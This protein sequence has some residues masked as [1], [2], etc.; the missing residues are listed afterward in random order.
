M[1]RRRDER[2]FASGAQALAMRQRDGNGR[3]PEVGDL[4]WPTGKPILRVVLVDV[5]RDHRRML[6]QVY[7]SAG[8]SPVF[9]TSRDMSA[10]WPSRRGDLVLVESDLSFGALHL[11]ERV[12]RAGVS[13]VGVLL[14]WWSD[15]EWEARHA[16]DF[17]LHV[18]LAPDEVRDMLIATLLR[19]WDSGQKSRTDSALA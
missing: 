10:G 17:V 15:L 9:Q 4:E 13:P 6:R 11:A 19:S 16:V 3:Q 7:L 8:F 12:R 2:G 14:N 1:E 5:D 18:P